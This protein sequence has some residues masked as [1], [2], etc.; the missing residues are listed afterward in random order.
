MTRKRVS[1]ARISG[2]ARPRV[3]NGKS[4]VRAPRDDYEYSAPF[5]LSMTHPWYPLTTISLR[6][7][8]SNNVCGARPG[9][10]STL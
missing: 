1:E 10:D 8:D 4:N 3:V 6:S 9:A 7:T 5:R 2:N